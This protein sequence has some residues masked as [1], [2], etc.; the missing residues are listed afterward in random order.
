MDIIKLIVSIQTYICEI[1]PSW[2]I[3]IVIYLTSV[4]LQNSSVMK[5]VWKDKY[6]WWNCSVKN[7]SSIDFLLTTNM[8]WDKRSGRQDVITTK[9]FTDSFSISVLTFDKTTHKSLSSDALVLDPSAMIINVMRLSYSL[10]FKERKMMIR[11]DRSEYATSVGYSRWLLIIVNY[12]WDIS[13]IQRNP[14]RNSIISRRHCSIQ[15][16]V[17]L[18][19]IVRNRR[20]HHSIIFFLF[21]IEIFTIL[22]TEFQID[23][24]IKDNSNY[25]CYISIVWKTMKKSSQ[26][27]LKFQ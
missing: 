8:D 16:S 27:D 4:R 14:K 11:L 21:Q 1:D 22:V 20:H 9:Y 5:A 23:Q 6:Q 13:V 19:I 26:K 24:C 10:S 12:Q 17:Q 2:K 18:S 15:Y 3:M 25:I 7:I